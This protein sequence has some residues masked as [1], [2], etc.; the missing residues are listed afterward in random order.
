MRMLGFCL[1]VLEG[2]AG[3]DGV[4]PGPRGSRRDAKIAPRSLPLSAGWG[5]G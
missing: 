2:M 3:G 5:V 4:M 1:C